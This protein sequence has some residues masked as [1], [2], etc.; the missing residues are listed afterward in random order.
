MREQYVRAASVYLIWDVVRPGS[1][2]HARRL[3]CVL[4]LGVG[5]GLAVG[6]V[7]QGGGWGIGCVGGGACG[8]DVLGHRVEALGVGYPRCCET[9]GTKGYGAAHGRWEHFGGIV[10]AL[11]RRSED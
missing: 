1:L 10:M 6:G 11:G 2:V 5:E 4:D 9:E 8:C 7:G 3:N